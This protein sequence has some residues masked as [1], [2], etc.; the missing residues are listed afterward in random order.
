MAIAARKIIS[1]GVMATVSARAS[2]SQRGPVET[3]AISRKA[4]SASSSSETAMPK[5]PF[6]PTAR[7]F[8][9]NWRLLWFG[10]RAAPD[11][12]Q[13]VRDGLAQQ[14]LLRLAA[15]QRQIR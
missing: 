12:G 13:D 5:S 6:R 3:R 4:N 7:L 10:V 1:T 2:A 9:G 8:I 15:A 14:R 11:G